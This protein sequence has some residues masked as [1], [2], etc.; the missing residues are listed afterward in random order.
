MFYYMHAQEFE[1]VS[2]PNGECC[3][4]PIEPNSFQRSF[5]DGFHDEPASTVMA[6]SEDLK[7]DIVLTA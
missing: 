1:G 7:Y 2:G 3:Q 4:H 5:A 6:L